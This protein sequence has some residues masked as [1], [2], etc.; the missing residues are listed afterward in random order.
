MNGPLAGTDDA[1]PTGVANPIA[2][3]NSPGAAI[4]VLLVH[5][6]RNPLREKEQVAGCRTAF[7]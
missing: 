4:R 2:A 6:I 1:A 7:V 3:N 5:F